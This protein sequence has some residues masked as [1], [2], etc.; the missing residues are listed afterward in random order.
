MQARGQA[1]TGRAERLPQ[2]QH[3]KLYNYMKR[4]CTMPFSHAAAGVVDISN[5]GL[6]NHQNYNSAL[7]TEAVNQSQPPRVVAYKELTW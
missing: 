1:L 2:R 7:L 3:D 4:M 5:K 6:S